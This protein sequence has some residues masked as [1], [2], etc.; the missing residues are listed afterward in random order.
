M[1]NRRIGVFD[2]GLGGLTVMKE[3]M[4]LLPNESLV[5]FGDT[6]RIPYGTKSEETVLKYTRSDIN[7]LQT[8]H[9]KAI[10]AACGTASSIALPKLS[11]QYDIP[12]LG[13]TKAASRRAAAVTRNGRVG[14]I[15]TT[16]TIRSG[17]YRSFLEEENPEIQTV[18]VACP[19]FVPLV[20]YGYAEKEAA[21][22]IAKDYLQEIIE[23]GA[24][25]LILGCTHY[26]LLKKVIGEVLGDS[27]TLINPGECVAGDV[28]KLLE[29][30][31]LLSKEKQ[32]EQYQFY[33]SDDPAEF[34]R[35]G[36][37]FLER[38]IDGLVSRI[39]IEKYN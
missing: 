12:L 32:T 19:M 7:F 30:N 1:D 9:L 35:L 20:E 27:V 36:S 14:V 5:Y 8:F 24:D 15:G 26:P 37:M 18:S 23:S 17:A 10:I 11:G 33:V 22:M 38:P 6:G 39:D 25:T 31:D 13:V 4:A 29:E 16:G 2:S 34:I 28:K 3:L 21:K